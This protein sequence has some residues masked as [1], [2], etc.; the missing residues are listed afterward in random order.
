MLRQKDSQREPH[1]AGS[2]DGDLVGTINVDS[3]GS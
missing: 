2:G 1:I 3:S